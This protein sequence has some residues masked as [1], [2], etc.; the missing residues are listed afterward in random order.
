MEN[1]DIILIIFFILI[2]YLL[3]CDMNNKKQFNELKENFTTEG[4]TT[5]GVTT[6]G[7]TTTGV[8]TKAIE[9]ESDKIIGSRVDAY[10]AKRKDIPISESIKNLG[11]L[12]KKLQNAYGNFRIPANIEV[13]SITITD[14]NPGD[15][16]RYQIGIEGGKLGITRIDSN[17]NRIKDGDIV[18]D[19]NV[20]TVGN[21]S[22]NGNS[23]ING[24]LSINGKINGDS[25]INGN[26]SID[27]QLNVTERAHFK[28]HIDLDDNLW[29]EQEK[30]IG[31]A[32]PNSSEKTG[33]II[34][35]RHDGQ[36][37]INYDDESIRKK[38]F[39]NIGKLF[40]SG[41]THITFPNE[42]KGPKSGRLY[43]DGSID[44]PEE[45]KDVKWIN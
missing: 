32:K 35:G 23:L 8:T 24:N 4:V 6:T 9:S 31:W 30:G 22:I 36:I 18:L 25:S 19:G 20:R 45:K 17:N 10:L 28:S 5:T 38:D 2:L 21:S 14:G 37:N 33:A 40:V 3:Y 39:V 12:S 15:E 41:D 11:I 1:K 27:G 42:G 7:V 29:I 26:L 16:V 34:T 13:D 44:H 43:V